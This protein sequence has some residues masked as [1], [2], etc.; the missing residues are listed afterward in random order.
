MHDDLVFAGALVC[1]AARKMY[2]GEPAGANLRLRVGVFAAQVLLL[3]ASTLVSRADSARF[4]CVE[5]SLDA[6]D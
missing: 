5:T 4:G 3:A 1:W 6:A 2:P